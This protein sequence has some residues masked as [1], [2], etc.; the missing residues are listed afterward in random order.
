MGE[1][2]PAAAGR[3]DAGACGRVRGWFLRE[4][5]GRAAEAPDV[6]ARARRAHARARADLGAARRAR[7]R[8]RPRSRG[9]SACTARRRTWRVL[10]GGVDAR[11]ALLVR[12]YDYHPAECEG[13]FLRSRWSGT[14]AS[15]V[16]RLPVGRARRHER[17]RPGRGAGLRR[18]RC[19]GEGFGI[20]LILRY[21][22]ETCRTSTK[23]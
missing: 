14:R 12:N 15:R 7:R 23:R 10:A 18:A 19:V 22:L 5:D 21:V 2:E 20:P 13:T 11:R 4:G 8:R 1:A 3:R 17:A 9:C 6:T 16:E